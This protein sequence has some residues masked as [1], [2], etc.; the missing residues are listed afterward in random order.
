[1]GAV[2]LRETQGKAEQE[3]N[4]QP[5]LCFGPLATHS[6]WPAPPGDSWHPAEME[7]KEDEV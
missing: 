1:M 7:F 3:A 5:G 4:K 6:I 2:R